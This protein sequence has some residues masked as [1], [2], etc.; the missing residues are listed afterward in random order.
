MAHDKVYGICESK[1]KVEVLAKNQAFGIAETT[2]DNENKAS[3]YF[4][5]PKSGERK[6]FGGTIKNPHCTIPD[7][8]TFSNSYYSEIIIKH[9]AKCQ[10]PSNF[11][12]IDRV[13]YLNN[14]L[15]ITQ[16]NVLHY[17]FTYDGFNV[18]CRCAGYYDDNLV[19]V[20]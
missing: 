8:M 5:L 19:I 9:T 12:N 13:K 3:F 11:L 17:Y 2:I 15:D 10:H 7:N 16:F 18:C 1:C 6:I 4:P 14:D 20:E